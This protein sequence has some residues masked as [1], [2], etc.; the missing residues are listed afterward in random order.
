MILHANPYLRTNMQL[1]FDIFRNMHVRELYHF[2]ILAVIP[3]A[4]AEYS[5]KP[6]I[7]I[8]NLMVLMSFRAFFN[9]E[10]SAAIKKS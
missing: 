4:C 3:I 2:T 6:I 5:S 8:L 10:L 1:E 9:T 7:I